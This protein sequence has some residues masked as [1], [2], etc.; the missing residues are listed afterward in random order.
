MRDAGASAVRAAL[1]QLDP[2]AVGA[3]RDILAALRDRLA[4]GRLRVLVAG[5]AKRGKSTLINALLG[6]EVLPVGVTPLTAVATTVRAGSPEGIEVH[7]AGGRTEALSLES[8]TDFGT[9]RGNPGNCRHVSSITVRVDAP[10]LARGAELVDTPG[11]G[12]V[13]AHN[14]AAAELALPSMDAAIL[15]LTSDPPVSAGEREL[16]AR[17]AGLSAALFIVLNKADYLDRHG[18]AE[19]LE[20]TGQ[21]A[22]EVTGRKER[23]YPMSARA[24]MRPT[25]DGGF[26]AF[27]ADFLSYLDHGRTADL[28]VSV[29]AHVRRLARLMLDEVVLAE[30]AA[31][32]PGDEAAAA[33]AA[34][35]ARLEAVAGRRLSA[36]DR[37]AGQAR[38]LLVTL[39]AAADAAR[40]QLIA[41]IMAA[42]TRVLSGELALVSPADIDRRGRDRLVVLVTEAV[43]KWRQEQAGLLEAGLRSVDEEC[44]AEMNAELAGVRAAAAEL[45]GVGLAIPE[46]A[47][48]LSLDD[49]F[50]YVTD[51][52]V[53]QSELLAGSLRRR[54]PGEIGREVARRH[55][56]SEVPGLVEMQ[57]GRA[58]GDLQYR[59]ADATRRL[60]ADLRRRYSD[61]TSRL[62]TALDR[63]AVIRAAASDQ[64]AS[65]LAHLA[66]REQALLAVISQLPEPAADP[67]GAG[68]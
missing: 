28:Q 13:H 47:T 29:A 55:L 52:R 9:E 46:P 33:V 23:I 19:A 11:T 27:A 49:R 68:G 8:L 17:I 57:V 12:S 45:L 7:F 53:D 54:L 59:L 32:L 18:L 41:D 67:S 14:T 25:G 36:E 56:L 15:V 4:S 24:A 21:V 6:R 22:R 16:L 26:A 43:E 42:I 48:R 60:L 37:A 38:R 1:V 10:V 2:L 39:N 34:F 62:T 30:R 50:F 20:F 31:R 63:A 66:A 3:D 40:P 51:E 65:Q 58:R 64:S 5:E 44:A 61:S 35:A